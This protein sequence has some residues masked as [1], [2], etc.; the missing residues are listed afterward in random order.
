LEELALHLL[1][2]MQNS[3]EARATRLDLTISEAEPGDWVEIELVDN[4]RGMDAATQAAVFDP[5]F[6]SRKTRRVGLGLPL[7]RATA[8]AT[9]GYVTLT[10]ELG[11][12][13]TLRARFGQSHID[14]PPLGDLATTLTSV[15]CGHPEL[16]VHYCHTK[17]Q[18]SFGLTSSALRGRLGD[19]PLGSP[20]VFA[21][22]KDYLHQE[23]AELRGGASR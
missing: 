12:G 13:A 19:V 5:F 16:D 4:G 20:A 1:D 21:W 2:V 18:R 22:L 11:A 10:S 7:M 9:G 3:I 23:I 14:C 15:I 8:E 6:T 17:G